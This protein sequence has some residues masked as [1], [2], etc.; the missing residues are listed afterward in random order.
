MSAAIPIEPSSSRPQAAPVL[1]KALLRAAEL[2]GLKKREL[3][4][5]LGTS[6]ASVSRLGRERQLNPKGKEM[7]L[8]A[9]LLRAF[10]SLDALVG[11]DERKAAAWLRAR[12]THLEGVPLE[13]CERAEGLV[14]VVQYLDAMRGTL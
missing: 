5:I 8:A 2:W 11:G 9:L 7:E 13:L 4:Q 14:T 10:R 3:A 1:T 6:E 12:N